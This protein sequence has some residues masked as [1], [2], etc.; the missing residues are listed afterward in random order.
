MPKKPIKNGLNSEV[1]LSPI[2]Q[3]KPLAKMK[4]SISGKNITKLEVPKIVAIAKDISAFSKPEKVE[5]NSKSISS[6]NGKKKRSKEENEIIDAIWQHLGSGKINL[7]YATVGYGFNGR[8]ILDHDLFVNL[9]INYGFNIGVV[10]DFID[11]F[12]NISKEDDDFPMVMI[13]SHMQKIYQEV[14]NI[15][16]DNQNKS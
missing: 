6:R 16:D 3:Q 8:P 9:L 15:V 1:D 10:L 4:V 13:S 5:A 7:K 11:D 14:E 2:Q 12:N